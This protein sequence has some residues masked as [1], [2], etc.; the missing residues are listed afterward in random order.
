[1]RSICV[2]CGSGFGRSPAYRAAAQSL[3]ASL[4]RHG[5]AL[6]YG[7]GHVGLMGVVAD[8]ALSGGGTVIGVI[9]KNLVAREVEHRG[10]SQLFEV[11]DMHARKAKMAELSDAF[12]ALPGGLGTFDELFEMLTWAQLRMHRKPVALLNV[13]G[14]FEPLLS[15]IEH[16]IQEGF[17]AP[18]NRSLLKVFSSLE[19]LEGDWFACI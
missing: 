15:A 17:V 10:L 3:G 12:I 2:Y 7:G 9:P 8:A 1:M 19:A 14:Y 6:V 18:E 16:A 13:E 5:K 11:D 4:A